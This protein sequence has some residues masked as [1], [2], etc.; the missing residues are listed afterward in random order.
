MTSCLDF[1]LLIMADKFLHDLVTINSKLSYVM[2][3]DERRKLPGENKERGLDAEKTQYVKEYIMHNLNPLSENY[4]ERHERYNDPY[5]YERINELTG[6]RQKVDVKSGNAKLSANQK[7]LDSE[8][9]L[10][11]NRVGRDSF[12]NDVRKVKRWLDEDV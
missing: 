10:E 7:K 12:V 1:E 4:V 9:G 3:K 2:N 5:D 8:E 11:V 6:E